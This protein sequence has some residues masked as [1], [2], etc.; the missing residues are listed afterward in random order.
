MKIA[1]SQLARTRVNVWLEYSTRWRPRRESTLLPERG[2]HRGWMKPIRR[3]ETNVS[4]S[5]RS[6]EFF[7]GWKPSGQGKYPPDCPQAL[8]ST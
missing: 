3:L 4:A 1:P 7:I 6:I 5:L 8:S 2:F